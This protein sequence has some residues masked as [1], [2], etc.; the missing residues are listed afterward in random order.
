M[1]SANLNRGAYPE[2]YCSYYWGEKFSGGVASMG[3][4]AS[5]ASLLEGVT[6]MDLA[7]DIIKERTFKKAQLCQQVSTTVTYGCYRPEKLS[8]YHILSFIE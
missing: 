1:L 8:F 5:G 2:M 3:A 7:L 6:R 4:Q